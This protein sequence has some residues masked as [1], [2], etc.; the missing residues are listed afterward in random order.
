MIIRD[1]LGLL[2]EL[3]QLEKEIERAET[4]LREFYPGCDTEFLLR[5]ILDKHKNK[6]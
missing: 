1:C 5:K 6:L 3:S 2:E 4:L